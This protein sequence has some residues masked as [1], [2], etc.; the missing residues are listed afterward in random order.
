MAYYLTRKPQSA[1]L[2]AMGTQP[3]ILIAYTCGHHEVIQASDYNNVVPALF[4]EARMQHRKQN[5][6]RL[7]GGNRSKGPRSLDDLWTKTSPKYVSVPTPCDK[8]R[9]Q[10]AA[11]REIETTI[12]TDLFKLHQNISKVILDCHNLSIRYHNVVPA[13]R[14]KFAF[15]AD[16]QLAHRHF[17]IEKRHWKLDPFFEPLREMGKHVRKADALIRSNECPSRQALTDI[18]GS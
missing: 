16:C 11:P 1:T 5:L 9:C 2:P 13:A 7:F 8:T 4:E 17:A 3:D 15:D 10:K 14:A 6:A 12:K 18:F